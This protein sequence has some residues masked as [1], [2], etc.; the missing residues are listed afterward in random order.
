MKEAETRAQ[1]K[2]GCK[3]NTL[4]APRSVVA[5]FFAP[6]SSCGPRTL[7]QHEGGHL[8]GALKESSPC[9]LRRSETRSHTGG[10]RFASVGASC[11][12]GLWVAFTIPLHSDPKKVTTMAPTTMGAMYAENNSCSGEASDSLVSARATATA[13]S[14]HSAAKWLCR[15]V[16]WRKLLPSKPAQMSTGPRNSGVES[17]GNKVVHGDYPQD[18][19]V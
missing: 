7:R 17:G 5:R 12:T 2:F 14:A 15:V 4:A 3:N 13:L 11:L 9:E 6:A 16:M 18:I 1:M 8:H 10:G 19:H